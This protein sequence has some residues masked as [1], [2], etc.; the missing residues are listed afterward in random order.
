MGDRDRLERLVRGWHGLEKKAGS[1]AV[2]DFDCAPDVVGDVVQDR[3][4]VLDRLVALRSKANDH[5][6][7]SAVLDAHLGYLRALLG[8]RLGLA[9]YIEVTQGSPPR[10][11]TPD[12]VAAIGDEARRALADVDVAWDERTRAAFDALSPTV[13]A[14]DAGD[15]I[16]DYAREYEAQ[17]RTLTGAETTFELDVE[18]VELDAYWSYWLDGE[19]RSA[20]LRINQRNASFTQVDAYRFALHEVLGH[21]LQYANLTDVSERAE[22]PWPRQLAIHCPHQVLFE[23]L[24]QVLPLAASPDD[25]LVRARTRLDHYVQLVNAELHL[26]VNAGASASA[27]RNHALS[28]L[29]FWRATDVASALRD[30]SLDPQLRSYLWAYPAGIDWFLNVHDHGGSLLAEVLHAGYQRPL[31]PRELEQLWPAGP[32]IGG[33]A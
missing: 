2:I 9:E 15:V 32:R 11:W 3:F 28:R 25:P 12:Y 19:G 23:G 8:E 20:R 10:G 4:D 7:V 6:D 31:V 33:N 21:A 30:R 1:S 26:M 24:A 18:T 22:T 5:D 17:V 27:C 14:G 16:R 29:P 13:P